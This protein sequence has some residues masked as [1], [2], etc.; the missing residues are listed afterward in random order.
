MKYLIGRPKRPTM[1]S[2]LIRKIARPARLREWASSLR[3]HGVLYNHFDRPRLIDYV[4]AVVRVMLVRL[5]ATACIFG[6]G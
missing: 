5:D 2:F 1:K 6:T 3:V 4:G